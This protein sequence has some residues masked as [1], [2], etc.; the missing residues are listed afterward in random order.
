MD[1]DRCDEKML[2]VSAP[3]APWARRY[4]EV[5]THPCYSVVHENTTEL[6][7]LGPRPDRGSAIHRSRMRPHR[8]H[9][10][11]RSVDQT[12]APDTLTA[13]PTARQTR[14]HAIGRRAHRIAPGN[15]IRA[16]SREW[17]S[18]IKD[19][20]FI[21]M[22][23]MGRID[24][25]VRTGVTAH[26]GAPGFFGNCR[27]GWQRDA[28]GTLNSNNKK[29]IEEIST[30]HWINPRHPPHPRHPDNPSS[31]ML[32]WRVIDA[33]CDGTRPAACLRKRIHLMVE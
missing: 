24:R 25:I 18:S 20:R 3:T 27:S 6:S 16:S 11:A 10:T 29:Q 19:G 5:L 9:E 8:P 12:R 23:R 1:P 30:P 14:A 32:E 7:R 22:P 31:L 2:E 17:H 4:D 33:R 15:G 28:H 26:L 21:R 13:L